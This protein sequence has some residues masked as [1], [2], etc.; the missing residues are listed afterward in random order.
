[1]TDFVITFA[2]A[3]AVGAIISLLHVIGKHLQVIGT[4]LKGIEFHHGEMRAGITR[5]HQALNRVK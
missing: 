1:M 4:A 5:I 2:I 3:V